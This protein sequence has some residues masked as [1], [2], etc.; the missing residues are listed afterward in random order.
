M[1]TTNEREE[2]RII[3][4]KITD[5]NITGNYYQK[6]LK[7]EI[8]R[9]FKKLLFIDDT[10]VRHFLEKW[11][12]N[13][14]EIAREFDLLGTEIEVDKAED[15]KTDEDQEQEN[16]E[17]DKDEEEEIKDKEEES[18]EE[19]PDEDNKEE[20]KE[21]TKDDDVAPPLPENYVYEYYLKRANEL[22]Y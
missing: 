18:T 12:S 7:E 14:K 6:D 5:F 20:T 3:I 11:I 9:E 16:E 21:E 4:K 15:E 1:S 10:T 8:A 22:L 2:A 19:I 17:K 13:T